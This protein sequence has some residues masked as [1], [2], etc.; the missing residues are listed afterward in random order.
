MLCCIHAVF[1]HSFNWFSFYLAVSISLKGAFDLG[2][3]PFFGLLPYVPVF[4]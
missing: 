2:L 3:T 1:L 4:A